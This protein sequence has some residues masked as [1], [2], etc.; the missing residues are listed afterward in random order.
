MEDGKQKLNTDLDKAEKK[1]PKAGTRWNVDESDFLI[2]EYK[3]C[4]NQKRD[5][6]E[7]LLAMAEKFGRRPNGIRGRLAL[8]FPDIPG[9]DYQGMQQRDLERKRQKEEEINQVANPETDKILIKEYNQYVLEK[10]ETFRKLGLRL[11]EITGKPAHIL[12]ARLR[13]LVPDM[14]EFKKEDIKDYFLP[15][16][17]NKEPE[18]LNLDLS[19]NAE[20]AE[21]FRLMEE[22][23]ENIFLTGEAGT[24][25]STLLR[26]FKNTTHKNTAVLAPTGVAA[27]NVGGQTIH[28]FCGFGPDITVHKIKKVSSWGGKK[29][30]LQ[31]LNTIIIDEISMVRSDLLDC[32]DKFLRLNGPSQFLPFGGVQMIFVGDLYQLPPVEKDFLGGGL[33][34]EYRSPYFFDAH[35]FTQGNFKLLELKTVYRQKDRAFLEILNAVR[36][37][38]ATSAHLEILNSRNIGEGNK[39]NFEEFAVYLTPTN[40]RATQINEFFLS[41]LPGEEKVFSG[42]ASGKL[43]DKTPPAESELRLK[44]NT[45]IMMLNNDAK[46]R[47]VNGTMGK[48]VGFIKTSEEGEPE[49]EVLKEQEITYEYEEP[50]P[51]YNLLIKVELE[52]GE[53]VYVG[54]HTW[55]MFN[56]YLDKHTEKVESRTVG[57]FTQYPLKPAWALTIHKSQGKTFDK[58][59]IDLAGGTFAHG[60]LYVALSR[61]RTLEG[62]HLKRPVFPNDIKLD[63]RVVEFLNLLN[64]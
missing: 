13:Q 49:D 26:Y 17:N 55:E 27:I 38:A 9:W 16:K 32:V 2:S 20:M 29:E 53:T 58:V 59:Y 35:S 42:F 45:Q 61:C 41:K 19:T 54:K 28:S 8:N 39:F 11:A 43:E 51:Q 52:S 3:N 6:E 12:R 47:W 40:A 7:F 60:Q 30:L 23:R 21:A 25:K 10:R 50:L 15:K 22:T 63:N 48:V 37:N 57:T 24:G 64:S 14:V 34:A 33:F 36:N 56:F 5:F 46:R 62:L 18:I 1:Y 31:K 4:L 44:I